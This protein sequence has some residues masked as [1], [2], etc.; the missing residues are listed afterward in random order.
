MA[1]KQLKAT[2]LVTA[3]DADFYSKSEVA[4]LQSILQQHA[5]ERDELESI[6]GMWVFWESE[7]DTQDPI[8]TLSPS[9][10]LA[11]AIDST[12]VSPRFELWFARERAMLT[13]K[14]LEEFYQIGF[15]LSDAYRDI[16][17]RNWESSELCAQLQRFVHPMSGPNAH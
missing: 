6:L 12:L 5:A 14:H 11:R 15:Y 13:R 1:T 7:L 16:K 8:D 3:A 4:R 9:D 2:S 10:L 17:Q